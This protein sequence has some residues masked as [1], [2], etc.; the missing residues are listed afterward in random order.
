MGKKKV[1]AF[2]IMMF[3]IAGALYA[4]FFIISPTFVTKPVIEKPTLSGTDPVEPEHIE[5][6][7]NELGAYKLHNPPLSNRTPVI[8]LVISPGD[9]Y[10]TVTVENNMPKTTPGRADDPDIRITGSREVVA[11]LLTAEDLPAEAK[12]LS[13]EGKISVEILKDI[14]DLATMGYKS[15]YDELA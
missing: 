11:Q 10:F 14:T 6:L 9:L 3:V 1:L 5:Y 15:L 12:R 7:V 13:D 8:E 2:S 4:Y